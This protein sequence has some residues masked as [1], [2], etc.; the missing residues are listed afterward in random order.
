MTDQP[1]D[2]HYE[3]ID[4]TQWIDADPD[5]VIDLD[6]LDDEILEE[7]VQLPP[8]KPA[9][10][11]DTLTEL[12]DA[13][14]PGAGETA[15]GIFQAIDQL[16]SDPDAEKQSVEPKPASSVLDTLT[17]LDDAVDEDA[18]AIAQALN[19]LDD[20]LDESDEPEKPAAEPAGASILDTLTA[21]DDAVDS[22]S[23]A[24]GAGLLQA[25][26]QLDDDLQAAEVK[27]EEEPEAPVV[28]AKAPPDVNYRVSLLLPSELAETVEDLRDTGEIEDA[29]P[30]GIELT[31]AFTTSDLPAVEKA[32]DKWAKKHLPI[33]LEITGVLA[34]VVRAREYIAAWT[35]QPEE[36]LFKAQQALMKALEPL[37]TIDTETDF[38]VRVTI[39]ERVAPRPYPA[40]IAQMQRDFDSF[41]WNA[42]AVS[43]LQAP[44]DS[45]EWQTARSFT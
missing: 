30:P 23:P 24:V 43:L 16:Q 39:G 14:E 41:I 40:L 31:P 28:P 38:E 27:P 45:S 17:A 15:Q 1:D 4:D 7:E 9:S 44:L 32:L 18:T 5:D 19:Q 8:A 37:I 25:I 34:Q 2:L 20:D 13:V 35:L 10:V 36:E 11:L 33:Q 6:T 42:E 29:P 12:D 22:D 26:D 3:D 21:L